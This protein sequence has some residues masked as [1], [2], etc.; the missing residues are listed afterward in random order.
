[1]ARSNQ[2]WQ[3]NCLSQIKLNPMKK[4]TISLI[5]LFAAFL[6]QAQDSKNFI[7]QNYIEV[8]GVAFKEVTPDEI[9]L[10]VQLNEKDNKGKE[11]LETLERKMLRTLEKLGIDLKEQVTLKDLTSNFQF[12]F[13]RRT[14]VFASKEY[15]VQV[16]TAAQAGEVI[17]H[18]A[19]IG[20]SNIG[21]ERVS[22]SKEDELKMEVKLM[23]LTNA[24]QK[25]SMLVNALDRQLGTV[26]HIQDYDNPGISRPRAYEMKIDANSDALYGSRAAD[27]IAFDKLRVE[28]SIQVKFAID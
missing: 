22:Y 28:T 24:R 6:V 8:T 25:A 10:S 12:Y 1:M 15:T 16:K 7:D 3:N 26:L 2:N 9:Y 19:D 13:L 14:D 20:I 18:L 17:S 5:F 21:L 4:Y 11:S 27:A 23:A